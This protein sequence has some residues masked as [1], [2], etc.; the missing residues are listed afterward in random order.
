MRSLHVILIIATAVGTFDRINGSKLLSYHPEFHGSLTAVQGQ[1]DKDSSFQSLVPN[2]PFSFEM[3]P[4]TGVS[5]LSPAKG[6]ILSLAIPGAGQWYA[7]VKKKA[8]ISTGVEVAG[9]FVWYLLKKQGEDLR[10]NFEQFADE[11][12]DLKSWVEW[13]PYLYA[14]GEE[15]QAIKI[16]GTHHLRIILEDNIISSDTL[17]S[18][19]WEGDL[20]EIDV[21]RDIEFYEIIGKYDQFVSGWDDI[22]NENGGEEWELKNKDV[23]EKTEVIIMTKNKKKYLNLRKDSTTA[24]QMASYVVSAI[25][26]NHAISAIDAFWETRRRLVGSPNLDTSVRLLFTPYS[27]FGVGGIS[28]SIS[29]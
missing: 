3:I 29:W 16:D 5:R 25:M 21:I 28:F 2:E 17:A 8:L 24:F 15:Y 1:S 7:G 11:H 27:R 6:L 14:Q 9:L 20:N 26:L 12:W 18:P 4:E 23:G 10:I 19:L 22:F 13:S